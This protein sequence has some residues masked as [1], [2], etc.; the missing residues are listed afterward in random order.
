MDLVD[1]KEATLKMKELGFQWYQAAFNLLYNILSHISYSLS[2]KVLDPFILSYGKG[3]LSEVFAD[4]EAVIDAVPV[5]MVVNAS[6]AA[7]AKHGN[8][9]N[10]SEVKVYNLG[11]SM[12]NPISIAQWI[13]IHPTFTEAT[14]LEA[15][16]SRKL[17]MQSKKRAEYFTQMAEIYEPYAFYN[18][19][20]DNANTQKIMEEM[21]N[22]EIRDFGFDM[23]SVNWQQY[24][25][26]IHI[27]GLRNHAL[28]REQASV[29]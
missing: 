11:S 4:P 3:L 14:A 16:L 24:F 5:D 26:R 8:A 20:F 17:R 10:R 22:E 23:K 12:A 18:G 19:R 21:S 7:M 25:S 15:K 1:E 9:A 2:D 6:I 29:Q 28:K 13:A 27:P